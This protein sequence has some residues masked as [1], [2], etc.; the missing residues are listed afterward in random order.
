MWAYARSRRLTVSFYGV[1]AL[2]QTRIPFLR[3]M[4]R[5]RL[6]FPRRLAGLS[7]LPLSAG[8]SGLT[9][10]RLATAVGGCATEPFSDSGGGDP[11]PVHLC[12]TA[13]LRGT[14]RDCPCGRLYSFQPPPSPLTGF[15]LRQVA[16]S[17]WRT[18]AFARFRS[19]IAASRLHTSLLSRSDASP[20]RS[21]LT[22]KIIL[23]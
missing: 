11:G 21:S 7:G 14:L 15:T 4:T 22:S 23:R 18:Y 20:S 16:T 13:P 9:F 1:S 12:S 2:S 19:A 5:Y 6:H 10:R 3:L 8:P 17:A